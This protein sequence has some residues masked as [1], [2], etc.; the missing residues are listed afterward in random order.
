MQV[1]PDEICSTKIETNAQVLI[2]IM[3]FYRTAPTLMRR[4]KPFNVGATKA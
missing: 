3:P 4:E 1:N 2:G